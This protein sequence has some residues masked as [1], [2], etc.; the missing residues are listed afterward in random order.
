MKKIIGKKLYDTDRLQF[1]GDWEYGY[2]GNF[3]YVSQEL[4]RVDDDHYVIYSIGG[5]NT[6]Y[7][8]KVA[9]GYTAGDDIELV[10]REQALD[11]AIKHLPA[12]DVIKAFPSDIE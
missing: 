9:D 1:V 3:D 12:D 8:R 5:A 6:S 11:W 2:G 7:A 4:Y 10:D